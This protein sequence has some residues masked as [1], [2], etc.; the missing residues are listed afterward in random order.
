MTTERPL[1]VLLA[2]LGGQGGA[3]LTDWLVEAARAA[4]YPAQATSIP[5]VAQRTGATTYYFELFPERNPPADPV[6]SPY[7]GAGDVDLVAAL[8]P[9]EAGRALERGFV[10]SGTTVVTST[11][12]VYSTA[13]KE[14][15]G[16]GIIPASPIL[17]GLSEVAGSLIQVDPALA[18][19]SQINAVVFGALIG[20]R[21]LPLTV[22]DGHAAIKAKGL[23]VSTNLA[24][25]D[26]GLKATR[27]GANGFPRQPAVTYDP[28]PSSFVDELQAY[29]AG[30]RPLVGHALTRLVD[31]QD[32]RYAR[33]YLERLQSILA[34]DEATGGQ[35]SDYVLTEEVARRLAAWMSYEDVMR[36]AQLKTRP[37]R[38]ARI[39]G[40][41]GAEPG[42]PVAVA[43]FLSPGPEE[44]LAVLPAG[45]ARLVPSR[46]IPD[47]RSLEWPTYT[48]W[49]YAVLRFLAALRRLRPRTGAFAREQAVIETWL[50][51]VTA[52]VSV[53][54][55]LAC[56]TARLAVWMRGYGN[57]RA[58]GRAC[59]E[60]L[61]GRWE[62]RLRDD[63]IALS[64]E[65]DSLLLAAR[66]DPDGACADPSS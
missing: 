13:E 55:E 28:P 46:I 32:E 24:A 45:I 54:Y 16:D 35:A 22:E 23:A 43:D 57:V 48:L 56:Q 9:T 19:G 61:F 62:E 6:F 36:V 51:A 7:P 1:C 26:T 31:Y 4:G 11:A 15:A 38:L 50:A 30:L 40:E 65:V 8:E 41:V 34:A 64:D 42:E 10:T 53:D 37:G 52:A 5:G 17:E 14:V 27:P 58:R 25:F 49:G 44:F 39:R 33:R 2:A 29:P 63:P 20:S 60:G 47:G 12:R 59:L 18:P 66:N 21:V 3:V